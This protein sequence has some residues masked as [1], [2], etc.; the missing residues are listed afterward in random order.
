MH[1][2]LPGTNVAPVGPEVQMGLGHDQYN[3]SLQARVSDAHW[4][5]SNRRSFYRRWDELMSGGGW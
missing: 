3:E 4:S 5:G 2:D 1:P